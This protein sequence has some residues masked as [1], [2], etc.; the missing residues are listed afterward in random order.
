[1]TKAPIEEQTKGFTS[2]TDA[3]E[4]PFPLENL[5]KRVSSYLERAQI[6]ATKIG[7][8]NSTAAVLSTASANRPSSRVVLVKEVTQAGLVFYTN[9]TSSKAHHLDNNPLASLLFYSEALGEQI[10]VEGLVC[11]VSHEKSDAY[12]ATRDRE[13]QVG[14]W[15][16]LQSQVMSSPEALKVRY[17]EQRAKHIE[18]VPR[19][20]HWGGYELKPDYF[21]FWKAGEHRLHSRESFT[22][23]NTKKLYFTKNLLYP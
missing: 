22:L 16:S 10:R 2:A 8:V 6:E 14:A 7:H 19:P 13:S 12:F 17:V 5:L 23:S 15:A 21:E 1:M 3:A 4:N 11:K 9:Y 18:T 20:P